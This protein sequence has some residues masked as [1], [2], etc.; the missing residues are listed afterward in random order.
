MEGRAHLLRRD[1]AGMSGDTDRLVLE[2]TDLAEQFKRRGAV[3][4]RDAASVAS[5]SLA[6]RELRIIL[7]TYRG[8]DAKPIDLEAED[9]GR[10]EWVPRD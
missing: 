4:G 1:D 7:S 3:E 2:L 5:F 10:V 9:E 6:A 8:P